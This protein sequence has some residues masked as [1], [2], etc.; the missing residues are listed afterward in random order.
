MQTVVCSRTLRA[1]DYPNVTI[2]SDAAEAVSELKAKAGRDIW[3]FGGGAL[4]CS[5]LDD[6]LVDTIELGVMPVLLS[7]GVPLLPPG[8]RSPRLRLVHSGLS[9]AGLLDLLMEWSIA[10][11]WLKCHLTV[12]NSCLITLPSVFSSFEAPQL[13]LG[14]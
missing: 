9:Q 12:Q 10:A 5:L 11:E 2:A 1:T 3:L 6:C 13:P 8:E 4:F 7:A 14:R